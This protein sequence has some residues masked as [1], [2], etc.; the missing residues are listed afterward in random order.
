MP[1]PPLCPP[2]LFPKNPLHKAR[3]HDLILKTAAQKT[4][5]KN[6]RFW[7]ENARF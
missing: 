6:I 5:R 7:K 3:E 1:P 2:P 4:N